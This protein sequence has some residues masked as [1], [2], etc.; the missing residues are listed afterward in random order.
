M[1]TKTHL[2]RI[3][4]VID[5]IERAQ[6]KGALHAIQ[7]YSIAGGGYSLRAVDFSEDVEDLKKL[8]IDLKEVKR[9]SY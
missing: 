9:L 8:I 4:R 2:V 3:Q 1:I 7:Q 5:N 6:K